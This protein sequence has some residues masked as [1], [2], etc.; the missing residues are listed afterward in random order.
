MMPE[1]CA[2]IQEDY[3]SV[4]VR[5]CVCVNNGERERERISDDPYI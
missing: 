3:S 1:Q 5:V 4:Y 2:A